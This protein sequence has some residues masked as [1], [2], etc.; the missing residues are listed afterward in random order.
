MDC[1]FYSELLLCGAVYIYSVGPL[2]E[3]TLK[4]LILLK[5]PNDVTNKEIKKSGQPR[6]LNYNTVPKTLNAL[7]MITAGDVL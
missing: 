4:V 3:D 1:C 6:A 5:S 2:D 7:N